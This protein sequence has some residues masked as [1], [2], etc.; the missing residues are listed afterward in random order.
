MKRNY[1]KSQKDPNLLKAR[2]KDLEKMLDF[3]NADIRA[4]EKDQFVDLI[5]TYAS[6]MGGGKKG[7]PFSQFMRDLGYYLGGLGPNSAPEVLQERKQFF[8]ELQSYLC[9]RIE[10]TIRAMNSGETLHL[11]NIQRRV[12]VKP[13]LDRFLEEPLVEEIRSQDPLEDEKRKIDIAFA[14]I[15]RD[16]DLLPSRLRICLRC[17]GVFYQPT[18]RGKRYCSLWCADAVRQARYKKRKREKAQVSD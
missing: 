15:I 18:S 9:A 11:C 5:A 2:R 7:P 13:S 6:F 1:W 16:L 8:S 10:E 4:I 17:R 14:N 3:L 12:V